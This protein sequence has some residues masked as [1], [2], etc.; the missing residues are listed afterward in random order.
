MSK[1]FESSIVTVLPAPP[2][3]KNIPKVH[4]IHGDHRVDGYFYMRE[5]SDPDVIAYLEAENTYT[6]A[7]MK[8][9]EVF[10]ETLYEEMLARIKQTD[11]TVPYRQGSYFYYSRT[12]EGKQYPIYCRKC[13]SLDAPEE[14]TL[15]VN[16]LAQGHSFMAVGAYSVSDDGNLLAFSTDKTGFRQYMLQVKDLRTGALLPDRVEK[17]VSVV[18][19]NDSRT[20]F[21]TIEDSAKRSYRLYRHSL[22]ATVDP[23]IYE[24]EDAMFRISAAKSRSKGFIFLHSASRTAS[25]VRYLP[26]G[27]PGGEWKLIAPREK[28]HEYDVDHHGDLFYFRSNS[29][30]RNFCLMT[31]PAA[32]PRRQNWREILAHRPGVML[33]GLELFKD[34]SILLERE[35]GL[36]QM[37]VTHLR[38]GQWHRIQFP[39]PVY[40]AAPGAN[41]EWEATEFRYSYQSLVTPNS[42]F[43]YDMEKRESTLLKQTE[44]L[45]GYDPARYRSERIS[46]T[47]ADGTRIPISLVCRK[48]LPRDGSCPLLLAGYGSYGISYPI[49]FSSNRLSLLDRGV[50]VAIAHIRGGGELGKPWHDQG[51]MR[52]KKNTFTDFI[53]AAEHLI[54][55]KYTASDRLVLQGGSAGGLLVGAVANLRPDLCRAVVSVAPF[56]DVVNSMLDPSLP[57][58]A[59][60]WEEWG[61]PRRQPDY[62]YIKSYCPYT[63]VAAKDYPAMLVKASLN[64]SQVMF[65]EPAKYVA[66]LR[67]LKTDK[68]PLLLK[69]NMAAGHGGASGRYDALRETAFDYAFVL[70]QLGISS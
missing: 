25:E 2:V 42:V 28:D 44:V 40:S 59:G 54:S 35:E 23:L 45:G 13:G 34:Y 4:V 66:K 43:D 37:R 60:E 26:A 56:V 61:D 49:S 55:H 36:P 32:D 21:Y 38:T 48:D 29:A 65:W 11:L 57:L 62:E 64:D 30:G 14:I 7:A 52:N 58:T 8:Q 3:A 69:I 18:W 22:G 5:K 53:A 10:Q 15:D 9:T 1:Y 20:L 31:A 67:T 63:N 68:N 47:A 70:A 51:R 27:E 19:A 33:E 17:A 41:A 24:E 39:E 16:E 50:V 46:A 6:G 12:E